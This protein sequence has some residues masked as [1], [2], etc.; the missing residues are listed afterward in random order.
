M[1]LK[2]LSEFYFSRNRA[3]S[4][5]AQMG[6]GATLKIGQFCECSA[7]SQSKNMKKGKLS[8]ISRKSTPSDLLKTD[9]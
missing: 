8:F 3:L 9:S 1:E 5:F 7:A 2:I 6:L 4:D